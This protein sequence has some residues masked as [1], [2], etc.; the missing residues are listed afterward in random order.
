[1]TATPWVIL[2]VADDADAKTIKR[3]DARAVKA[4]RPDEDPIGFQ[5]L[6]DAYEWALAAARQRDAEAVSG[7][8]DASPEPEPEPAALP[9]L[10]RPVESPAEAPPPL[11]ETPEPEAS[12]ELH[13]STRW[14][15][16]CRPT[17]RTH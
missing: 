11:P 15:P 1:M 5:R 8:T 17:G 7:H 6:N 10:G 9:E 12:Q 16:A 4:S 14:R 3:A 2:G 13:S